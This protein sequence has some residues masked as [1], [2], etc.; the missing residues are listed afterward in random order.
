MKVFKESPI[1]PMILCIFTWICIMYI[2]YIF[3]LYRYFIIFYT[4]VLFAM[5]LCT[6]IL[7]FFV[8]KQERRNEK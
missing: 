5:A 6:Y 1:I 4:L 7:E 3:E 2:A 8:K